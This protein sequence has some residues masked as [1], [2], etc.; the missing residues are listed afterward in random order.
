MDLIHQWFQNNLDIVFFVYGFAFVTMGITVLVQPKQE[1]EFKIAGILWLLALFGITHGIN[2]LLDMWAIIKGRYPALDL[3]R[4]F[5]LVISYIFLFEFG[6]QF[7]RIAI[8]ESPVLQ[9]KITGLLVWWL[10]PVIG[11]F[12][13]IS[14]FMS[15]DFWKT[16]SI[17]TRYLLGFPGGLLI[18][19]GFYSYYNLKKEILE[20][21]KVRKY[22]LFGGLSFLIY[23]I[24]G[25]AVVP[26]GNFF[27]SSWL[28]TD[29]FFLTVKIP[30]QVFRAI[31][32]IIAAW[33]ALGILK[34]FN[35]EVMNKLQEAHLI[36]KQQLKK[37]EER[38]ME[39]A[40]TSSDII[41]SIDTDGFII[42][43][44]RQG[45][46]HLG[47]LQKELIGRHLKE[48]CTSET[49][50]E[51]E[52]GLEKLK[53]EGSLFVD[54]GKMIKKDG[55]KLDVAVYSFAMYDSKKDFLGA[56]LTIR[57]FTEKERLEEELKERIK[58]LEQFYDMAIGRELKMKELR[59]E[60]ERLKQELK[61]Y[62]A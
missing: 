35:W 58:E 3:V 16:G 57:D 52:N 41:H 53:R 25:G 28:N 50:K 37:S 24:L 15:V 22:F 21:L 42:C 54:K 31:C 34:I 29:S 49:W 23:G 7:I 43:T 46:E 32:A 5:M 44:N 59:E 2:E 51:I 30:V 13:L 60:I 56:R 33:A 61:E 4:W 18:G 9:K 26:K 39:I 10:L 48:I 19:F 45:Y 17:W 47:Y 62:K 11:L 38:Y 1:S 27:P 8:Q 40:E 55:E 6:R 36:L 14:G 20:P 12:I